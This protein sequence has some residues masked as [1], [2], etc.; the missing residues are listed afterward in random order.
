MKLAIQWVNPNGLPFAYT[1]SPD[2]HTHKIEIRKAKT[3][4]QRADENE[5]EYDTNALVGGYESKYYGERSKHVVDVTCTMIIRIISIL[6]WK[7]ETS[8]H[9]VRSRFGTVII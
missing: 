4:R 7:K 6:N 1:D 2:A 3:H 9:P 5:G 8:E